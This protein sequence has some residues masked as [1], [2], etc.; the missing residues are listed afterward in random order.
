MNP[1]GEID[2]CLACLLACLVVIFA[3]HCEGCFD[4][5]GYNGNPTRYDT[6]EGAQMQGLR[7]T[8]SSWTGHL[9]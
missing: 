2:T 1:N 7:G 6:N 4:W 3:L 9:R 5:W 8:D